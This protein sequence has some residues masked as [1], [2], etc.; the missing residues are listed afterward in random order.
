[1]SQS[2]CVSCIFAVKEHISVK[3]GAEVNSLYVYV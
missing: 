1:M 2:E 3:S